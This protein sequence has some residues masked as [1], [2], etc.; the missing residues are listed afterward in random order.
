MERSRE[1]I[2]QAKGDLEHARSDLQRGFFDWACFS[3]QQAAEKAAKAVLQRL[4]AEPWGHAVADLLK[5]AA[6]KLRVPQQLID[7]AFELDEAYI[8]ATYPNAHPAGAPCE[9]Y[10]R[11]EAERLVGHAGKIVEFCAR[12]LPEAQ[13]G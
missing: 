13:P 10:T 8:P 2:E 12:V 3:S 6:K 5:E 4:G 11:Q 7:A 9:L 1:R